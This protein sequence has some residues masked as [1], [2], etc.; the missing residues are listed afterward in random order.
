MPMTVHV[1]ADKAPALQHYELCQNYPNPFNP[2][3]TIKYS[4]PARS[5][6]YMEIFNAIGHKVKTLYSGE[7]QPG[8]HSIL[9]NATDDNGT[10]VAAGIYYYKIH[11]GDFQQTRKMLYLK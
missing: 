9:W 3:T 4:L 11:A 6:V 2:S 8:N 7:Q 5:F 10:P 1:A